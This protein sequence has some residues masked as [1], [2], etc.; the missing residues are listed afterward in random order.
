MKSS[1]NYVF[2]AFKKT[3][4]PSISKESLVFKVEAEI[5]VKGLKKKND[6]QS[7]FTRND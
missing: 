3:G 5:T 1:S 7:D 6:F 2:R 4:L